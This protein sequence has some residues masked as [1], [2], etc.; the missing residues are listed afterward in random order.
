MGRV[1]TKLVKRSSRHI[2]EKYYYKLT[3]DFD[4]NKK[5]IEEVAIVPSK[6]IRNKISGYTTV[7]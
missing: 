6:R 1:R 4:T 2:I 7:G 5:I 3:Q